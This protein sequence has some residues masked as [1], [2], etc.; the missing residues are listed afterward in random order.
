MTTPPILP[1]STP[2]Q[3]IPIVKVVNKVTILEIAAG[4]AI[5]NIAAVFA[6]VILLSL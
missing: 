4:V 1:G 3:P 2:G 5:G 6:A